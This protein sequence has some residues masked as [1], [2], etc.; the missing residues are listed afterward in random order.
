MRAR[1]T[2]YDIVNNAGGDTAAVSKQLWDL[3]WQGQAAND[4]FSVLRKGILND[5]ASWE[6]SPEERTSR[7]SGFNRWQATRPVSGN[8][9]AL[10]AQEVRDPLQEEETRRERVRLLLRR[11]GI[12]FRELL[13]RE[14]PLLH[15]NTLFRTIRLMELS[16]ELVSGH[17]FHGIRTLQF[18][19][20]AAFR[21][22]SDGLNDDAV[23]WMNAA[24][25]ASLCG[26]GIEGLDDA[27]PSRH[28]TSYMVFHG[29]NP[30]MVLRRNGKDITVM[31]PP[32]HLRMDGYLAVFRDLL[33]RDFNPPKRINVE[34]I[35]GIKAT[36]SGYRDVFV[37]YG[38]VD[39]YSCLT[40]RRKY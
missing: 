8:W 37:R 4:S 25:P 6:P 26:T 2:F 14:L 17:F 13:E 21:F 16:G 5:F 29:I 32:D 10:A 34:T 12:L 36:V 31:V 38:F 35:N 22:L 20:P 39:D 18:M 1:Y 27:L 40:L 3:V 15:W 30:V 23:Y 24:D 11:Y 7:R 19:S 33:N 28:V 9:F